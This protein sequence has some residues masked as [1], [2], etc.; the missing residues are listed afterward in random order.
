MAW[1][2]KSLCIA[3]THLFGKA[4]IF[5]EEAETLSE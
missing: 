1:Y 4:L 5:S 2:V 3:K